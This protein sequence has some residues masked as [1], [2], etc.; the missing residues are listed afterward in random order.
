[1]AA[2][3]GKQLEAPLE[4]AV[5][6]VRP[7]IVLWS[8]TQRAVC[9]VELT[10]PWEEASEEGKAYMKISICKFHWQYQH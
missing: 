8:E 5:T 1:M 3:L 4:I 2:A 6:N 9:L 10:V 7:D